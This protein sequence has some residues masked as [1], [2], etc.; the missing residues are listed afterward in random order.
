[1]VKLVSYVL[2]KINNNRS[3]KSNDILG[4]A[5]LHAAV[6]KGH[7][8]IAELML[9]HS[10]DVN[11]QDNDGNSA[12]HFAS[13]IKGTSVCL[14]SKQNSTFVNISNTIKSMNCCKNFF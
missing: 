7:K 1:M 8:Q 10:G 3:K 11:I 12:L 6:L 9:N 2:V 13:L 5:A 14:Q 4:M